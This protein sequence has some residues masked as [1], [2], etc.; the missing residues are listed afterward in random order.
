MQNTNVPLEAAKTD[1]QRKSLDQREQ[2]SE[3]MRLRHSCSHIL[4]TAVLRLWPDALLDIGPPTDEGFY[5]DFELTHRFSPE[6]FPR[7][8]EEMRKV[9]KENQVFEKSLKTRDE[10]REYFASRGQ[11]FKVERLGDIPEGEA[12]SF[13]QNGDFVDLCAGPHVMRTGNVKPGGFKLLKVASAYFRGN[14]KNPQLQRLYGTA[15]KNKEELEAWVKQQEEA[16]RRDHRKIGAEMGLFAF[17]SEYVGPGLPLW[18]P[19]GTVLVEELERLAKETEFAGGYVRV[20]TPHLAKEKMYKTS[21][22]LPYYAESMFAPMEFK[23]SETDDIAE[24][25]YLKAMNCPHH[26]RIFAAEPHSYRDLPL[27]LA[28]YGTCYRYE[29]SGELFGLM[30]VR[31][32]QMNDAHIYLT[33]EQFAAEFNAVNEMYLKYFRI[34]GID[35]Y[36]MRFSTHDPARLGQKF[37]NEPE[38]WK[39][40]EDMVRDVLKS[41]GINYVEVPNEAAFYGPKIDVQVWSAIGR[42][43]TIATNQ[44]DFAVP[45]RFGLVYKDRDNTEK[46]PLCIHRA[47]LGTHERFIGFLI[48]HYAGNFPLW[49]APEQVRVLTI[50]DDPALVAYAQSLVSELRAL[51]VRAEGDLGTNPIKAKIQDAEVARVH[52]ML[53]VGGRDLEAGQVSVRLH[54]KGP[55]GAKLRAE[56]IAEIATAIRERR[57]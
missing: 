32:M 19:K 27:R 31:S 26:H 48:E 21:G 8:E 46:T 35:R 28:E 37:V 43:F 52:T 49:L 3:L 15:F 13:Y 9:V 25:Y 42:E 38:L 47:P 2:M 57:P 34:F 44:V 18:L 39:Q 24:R 23:E 33:P 22:H 4:A 56:A 14:E 16:K 7:I 11:K 20:R 55:Q 36:L 10:A 53:V 41:S 51:Q 45:K 12:I 40:T 54:S 1:V 50:G 29:Q 17:D 30:R 5:Y 6:D